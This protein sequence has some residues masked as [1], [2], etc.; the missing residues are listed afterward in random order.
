MAVS[1]GQVNAFSDIINTGNMTWPLTRPRLYGC[2]NG[3][4]FNL[5]QSAGERARWVGRSVTRHPHQV[6]AGPIYRNTLASRGRNT[7]RW[8]TTQRLKVTSFVLMARGLSI[9]VYLSCRKTQTSGLIAG[10]WVLE[11]DSILTSW[12]S[13]G[14][15]LHS[16]S[17]GELPRHTELL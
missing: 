1:K 2:F 14:E 4:L 12:Q 16:T 8:V 3:I 13:S 7:D 9:R 5:T 17:G 10:D 11:E 6:V 15:L